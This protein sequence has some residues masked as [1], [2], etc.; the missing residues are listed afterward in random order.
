MKT[1][2]FVATMLLAVAKVSAQNIIQA[3]YFFDS[4]AGVGKNTLVTIANPLPDGNQ[5]F[6]VTTAGLAAGNHKLYIR[7]K[8]SDGKWSLSSRRNI[9]ITPLGVGKKITGGEYFFDADPGYSAGIPVTITLQDSAILQNFATVTNTLSPG[10]HKLYIRLRDTDGRWG[11]TSRRNVEMVNLK[12]Y[13]IAGVEYFFNSDP[14]AG[15]ANLVS[16]PTKSADSSFQFYIPLNK[17]P[18]G[19]QTLYIRARDSTNSNWSL[20]AWQADSVITSTGVDSVWSRPVT[21]S[22]NKVPDANTV[23]LLHHK[24]YVDV[25][26]AACKS[27]SPYRNNAQLIVLPNM[28]I[29]ITGHK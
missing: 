15:N 16:F 20:T 26:T 12:S 28:K 27:L 7:T 3:E 19:A 21:W 4:D 1:T 13:T 24:V 6:N 8:D 5:T 18:T 14:G 25:I 9:L 22:N 2:L 23:V 11:L 10:Y 17:I 29:T